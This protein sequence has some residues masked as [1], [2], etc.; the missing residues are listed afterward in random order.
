VTEKP[1][2][3]PNH[4]GVRSDRPEPDAVLPRALL[5]R[6]ALYHQI[7]TRMGEQGHE[8]MSS[9][10]LAA[11]LSIDPTLARKDMAMVNV[12]GRPKVGYQV[13]DVLRR[14]DEVLGLSSRKN[15][16]IIGSG[17][18]GGAI[19]SYGGFSQY[20]LKISAI[21]D[22]DYAK[23]GQSI[24]GH[25]I[26]PMEKCRNIIEIFSIEIAI[27]TVPAEA[28]QQLVDWLVN[29][30][31]RAIWNFSPVQV[32]APPEV[33]LRNENLAQGLAQLIHRLKQVKSTSAPP[34]GPTEKRSE[35]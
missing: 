23:V 34:A 14:L 3:L 27:L 4:A 21:F 20:G 6:L 26:L 35:P 31:I 17:R 1:R 18:L 5:E 7:V 22:S 19:A 28:A 15:A 8:T 33:V 2:S 10:S 30:G 25:V 24:S 16:I 32:K 9:A 11:L 12:T 29:R 13:A